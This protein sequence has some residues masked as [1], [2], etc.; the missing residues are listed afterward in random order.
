MPPP[1]IPPTLA[2]NTMMNTVKKPTYSI[3]GR[4]N[5]RGLRLLGFPSYV[6]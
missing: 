4:G 3:A 5:S 2:R 1:P 6:C